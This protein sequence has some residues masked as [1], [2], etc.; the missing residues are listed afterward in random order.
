M[1]H[2]T[3]PT[4]WARAQWAAPYVLVAVLA[5][6]AAVRWSQAID[7]VADTWHGHAQ[8]RR[9]DVVAYYAAGSLVANGLADKLYQPEAVAH[10][11]QEIL[12]R[13]AGRYGGLVFLNP[14]F[15][16]GAFRALTLLP[17]NQAQAAWFLLNAI[18]LFAAIAA[19][20]PEL[21]RLP[22]IWASAFVLAAIASFPVF[23]SFL[24]GQS[25][26]FILLAWALFYRLTKDRHDLPAGLMLAGTLIKPHLAIAPLTCLLATG[27]WRVLLAF[28]AG[29]ALLVT[30]SIAL[31][32]PHV[33]FVGYP[34]FLLGSL[35]WQREYGVDRAHMYGWTA[36]FGA[37]LHLSSAAALSLAIIASAVTL[38]AAVWVSRLYRHEGARPLLAL[39]IASILISPHM[40]AQDLQILLLPVLVASRRDLMTVGV[41]VLL[42]LLAPVNVLTV[43]VATPLLAAALALVVAT[44]AKVGEALAPRVPVAPSRALT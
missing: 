14:P 39:A 27:R 4:P 31:V 8:D 13:P 10:V 1:S 30:A 41:P 38:L 28:G 29:A 32:G 6:L 16:A 11:E 40:H 33:T 12:G 17:Y 5:L 9:E 36:F 15:V 21:R 37:V 3:V 20:L 43:A 44:P 18:A 25:S 22:R 19:L 34:E 2:L 42:F 35:R 23:W 24:Y 7:H 26:S